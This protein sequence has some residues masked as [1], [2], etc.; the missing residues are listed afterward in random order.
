M[1]IKTDSDFSSS[2]GQR[3]V[4]YCKKRLSS[5]KVFTKLDKIFLAPHIEYVTFSNLREVIIS[6]THCVNEQ[7]FVV[8]QWRRMKQQ[9][10][11]DANAVAINSPLI[12]PH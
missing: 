12:L 11:R 1:Y 2:K 8:F 10:K 4:Y 9:A 3:Q 5:N 6:L 7:G